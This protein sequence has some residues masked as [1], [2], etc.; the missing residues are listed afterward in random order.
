MRIRSPLERLR[1]R[2]Y[3]WRTLLLWT[4]V[5]ILLLWVLGLRSCG[6]TRPD[7]DVP[8]A[9]IYH[10]DSDSPEG[11]LFFLAIIAGIVLW[12]T[13]HP[14]V[15]R[16][17]QNRGWTYDKRGT[18]QF[19]RRFTQHPFRSRGWRQRHPRI[20]QAA[21]G[22]FKDRG[23]ASLTLWRGR[24]HFY[25]IDLVE[26]PLVLPGLAL[27]PETVA[28]DWAKAFGGA[29]ITLESAEFNARWRVFSS[30]ARY[31]HAVLHPRMMTRLNKPDVD[32]LPI[33]IDGGALLCW[34]PG[35]SPLAELDVHLALLTELAGLIPRH[36]FDDY[37][38]PRPDPDEM[39]P[40]AR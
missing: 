18:H 26:L 14:V 19:D 29:D 5:T 34:V 20:T 16:S 2:R 40:R 7:P 33:S 31:A 38:T 28:D 27:V 1:S 36:I 17:L 6:S 10:W 30:D 21:W 8:G 22:E 25:D 3:T 24:R 12:A 35:R 15:R 11:F 4:W 9:V 37:G 32:A 39:G 23:A 13:R